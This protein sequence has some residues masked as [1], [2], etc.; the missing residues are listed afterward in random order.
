MLSEFEFQKEIF[1]TLRPKKLPIEIIVQICE[2]IDN[3]SSCRGVKT[4]LD[5]KSCVKCES[6]KCEPC[7][8][9]L[10]CR[11]CAK[12][13]TNS[14][15][16]LNMPFICQDCKPNLCKKCFSPYDCKFYLT[17]GTRCGSRTMCEACEDYF[18]EM[19]ARTGTSLG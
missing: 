11:K 12:K 14:Y 16:Y 1:A 19:V 8:K 18:C 9:D 5:Y 17:E 10:V 2:L 13:S 3:C 4:S 6:L 7:S 15:F